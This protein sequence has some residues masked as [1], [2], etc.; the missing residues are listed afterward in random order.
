MSRD[1]SGAL[2]G[3]GA[4]IS[5]MGG[6]RDAGNAFPGSDADDFASGA[7]FIPY[8]VTDDRRAGKKVQFVVECGSNCWYWEFEDGSRIYHFDRAT[9]IQIGHANGRTQIDDGHGGQKFEDGVG[10]CPRCGNE[11]TRGGRVPAKS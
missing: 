5:G 9:Y 6:R 7:R 10:P 2:A 3:F 4:L 8:E 1:Y 11:H